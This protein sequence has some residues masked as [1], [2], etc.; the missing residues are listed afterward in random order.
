MVSKLIGAMALLGGLISFSG[1][2]IPPNIASA[3]TAMPKTT[4]EIFWV[5][6]QFRGGMRANR[7]IPELMIRPDGLYRYNNGVG[8]PKS[9]VLSQQELR[10]LKQRV[11]QANFS[12]IQSKPFKGTC[13]IAYD[14]IEVVYLFQLYQGI[15]E[16]STCKYAIHGK[17][18]LFQQLNRLSQTLSN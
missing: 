5:K 17:S 12:V 2:P 16:I 1:Q 14:G 18:Q 8:K 6:I 9:G 10:L 15:E 4:P 3:Q 11:Q 7:T 13:P